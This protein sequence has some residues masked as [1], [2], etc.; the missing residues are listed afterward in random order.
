MS[1][2]EIIYSKLVRLPLRRKES[3]EKLNIGYISFLKNG[4]ILNY[5]K[6]GVSVTC[7]FFCM[8]EIFHN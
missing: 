4:K 6:A 7:E 3:G 5:V 2:I 8:F 1:C